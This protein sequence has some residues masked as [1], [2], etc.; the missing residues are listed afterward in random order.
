V[1]EWSRV[2][3]TRGSTRNCEARHENAARD[4]SSAVGVGLQSGDATGLIDPKDQ[5]QICLVSVAGIS[6]SPEYR[7]NPLSNPVTGPLLGTTGGAA[8]GAA[9]GAWA[10]PVMV[11]TVPFGA[12]VGAVGGVAC[13]MASLAHPGAGAEFQSIPK[14]ANAG[15]LT[16][17]SGRTGCRAVARKPTDGA[18]GGRASAGAYRASHRIRTAFAA[19]SPAMPLH[20]HCARRTGELIPP[21]FNT[22]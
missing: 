7:P 3:A 17:A 15:A 1:V 4:R 6:D 16:R 22:T 10:W 18:L 19:G 20:A 8:L 12:V 14:G 2:R 11:V 21:R 5:A 9:A 13:G